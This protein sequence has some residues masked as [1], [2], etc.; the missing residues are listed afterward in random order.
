MPPEIPVHVAIRQELKEAAGYAVKLDAVLAPLIPVKTRQPSGSFHGKVDHS[1]PPWRAPVAHAHTGLHALARKIESELRA[2]TGLP[3][4]PRGGSDGNTVKA[5]RALPGLAEKA[6]DWIVRVYTRELEKWVRSARMA[7]ELE[8]IPKRLPRL[9]GEAEHPCPWCKNRT[10]RML[11]FNSDGKGEV[12]CANPGC[13]DEKGRRP[14][15]NLEYFSGELV[16][17]WQDGIIG[18]P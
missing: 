3:Q 10:L 8:E 9:P 18:N 5:L 6:D 15:A 11:P 16:L 1:Q 17:R 13:R 2:D 14:C 4:R 12:R 7:L